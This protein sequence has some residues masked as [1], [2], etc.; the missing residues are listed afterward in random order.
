MV[1][2]LIEVE[3]PKCR[4]IHIVNLDKFESKI[5]ISCSCG[6]LFV[7]KV[8]ITVKD[9]SELLSMLNEFE[10]WLREEKK[11][12]KDTARAYARSIESWIR[13]GSYPRCTAPF[14]HFKEFLEK[15]KGWNPALARYALEI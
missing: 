4:A 1:K 11:L 12:A 2:A 13:R 9:F 10:Q 5:A 15:K 14:D 6:A 3:C 7:V 8:S